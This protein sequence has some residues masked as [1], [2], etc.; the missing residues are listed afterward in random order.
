MEICKPSGG[1]FAKFGGSNMIFECFGWKKPKE[2]CA[3]LDKA[4]QHSVTLT[5]GRDGCDTH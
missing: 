2:F 5:D 3:A 1:Y 4:E